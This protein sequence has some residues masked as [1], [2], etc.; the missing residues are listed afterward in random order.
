MNRTAESALAIHGVAVELIGFPS[1]VYVH[2]VLSR[3]CLVGLPHRSTF[4]GHADYR[5]LVLPCANISGSMVKSTV[6]CFLTAEAGVGRELRS[7]A[8]SM[9]GP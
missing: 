3:R 2:L 6:G 8:Q 4:S 5:L 9:Q 7:G 1:S